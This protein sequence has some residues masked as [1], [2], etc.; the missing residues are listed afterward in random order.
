MNKQGF[1]GEVFLETRS[2]SVH[3]V[4]PFLLEIL[5]FAERYEHETRVTCI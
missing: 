4:F 5:S 2:L 3:L 1:W